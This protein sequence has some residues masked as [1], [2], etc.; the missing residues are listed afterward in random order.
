MAK[1]FTLFIML[2]MLSSAACH[3]GVTG[4]SVASC[5][6]SHLRIDRVKTGNDFS[7][8]ILDFPSHGKLPE[9]VQNTF[10]QKLKK[11]SEVLPGEIERKYLDSVI[12]HSDGT[13]EGI[14]RDPASSGFYGMRRIHFESLKQYEEAIGH[15][16]NL[17]IESLKQR[18]LLDPP[19]NVSKNKH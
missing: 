4:S 13:V 7:L 3:A 2:L 9:K 5:I 19:P 17:S 8:V 1:R 11:N 10:I 12:L 15:D 18:G 6:E 14:L 16:P